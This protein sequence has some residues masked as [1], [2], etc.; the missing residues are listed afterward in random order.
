M[1]ILGLL[2]LAVAAVALGRAQS[3]DIS[4]IGPQPGSAPPDFQLPDQYGRPRSLAS[5][6]G[7]R[8]TMLVFFRSAE[9]CPYCKTQ[10]LALQRNLATVTKEGYGLAALSYDRTDTLRAFADRHGVTFPLLSDAGSKTIAAWGLLNREASGREAGIPH[11]GI[12][13]IGRDRRIVDRAFEG[14]YQERSTAASLLARIGA[15]IAAAGAQ[16]IAA[17]HLA[18]RAGTSDAMAAPG[19]RITLFVDATPGPKIHV[20]SPEEKDYIPVTLTLN[21]SPQFRSH[22]VR[23]PPSGTYFFAPLN[24]TVRV[25]DKPFRVMQDV[26]LSLSPEL[27]Q[28]AA[29]KESMTITGTFEYQACDDAVCYRPERVPLTWR[30][31]LTPIVR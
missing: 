18:L 1:K 16:P 7:A 24:E 3:I 5:L 22:A 6:A 31:A 30:I 28:R 25:F 27:R 29:G 26:T 12:F 23:F 8:G 10:L 2:V 14:V 20:Y 17:P 4:R 21:G 15:P 19:E 13:I 11:P 9:W